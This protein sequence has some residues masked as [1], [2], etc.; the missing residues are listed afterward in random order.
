MIKDLKELQMVHML[1]AR[2]EE[3]DENNFFS[4]GFEELTDDK[5]TKIVGK[6]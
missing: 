1:R 6:V 5:M 4:I 3:I 2:I